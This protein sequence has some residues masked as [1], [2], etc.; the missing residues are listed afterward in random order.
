VQRNVKVRFP[1]PQGEGEP[2]VGAH[3]EIERQVEPQAGGAVRHSLQT[4]DEWMRPTEYFGGPLDMPEDVAG[5]QSPNPRKSQR[6]WWEFVN[7]ENKPEAFY[8]PDNLGYW[9]G[10]AVRVRLPHLEPQPEGAP[11]DYLAGGPLTERD[12]II[13][14]DRR[15][16]RLYRI[17]GNK[18]DES[19]LRHVLVYWDDRSPGG[20]QVPP[21]NRELSPEDA[22]L[23]F[24]LNLMVPLPPL[25]AVPIR[26]P[27]Q[28]PTSRLNRD[29]QPSTDRSTTL[30]PGTMREAKGKPDLAPDEL[31]ATMK[32]FLTAALELGALDRVSCRPFHEIVERAGLSSP[33]SRNVRVAYDRLK[34]NGLMKARRGQNGGSW[35]T[36]KGRQWLNG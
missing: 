13:P 14:V 2:Q 23:W 11:L 21:V 36:D 34:A 3:P 4:R 1:L 9:D 33:G 7:L 17:P 12:V 27:S 10:T 26:D 28:D 8:E 24:Q 22:A 15:D 29:W 6:G 35:I 20:T 25:E 16:E 30:T 18:R 32:D 31:T 5:A 19:G